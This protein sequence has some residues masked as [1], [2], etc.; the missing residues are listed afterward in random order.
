[1]YSDLN[2]VWDFLV[3]IHDRYLANGVAAPFLNM[4]SR[5][6]GWKKPISI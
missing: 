1:M 6:P 3:E 5:P 2:L 4:R